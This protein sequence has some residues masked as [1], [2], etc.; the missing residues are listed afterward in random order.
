MPETPPMA[1]PGATGRVGGPVA[2]LRSDALS[3]AAAGSAAW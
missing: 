2:R 3:P 1:V